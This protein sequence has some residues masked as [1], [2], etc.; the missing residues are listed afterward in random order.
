MCCSGAAAAD[1]NEAHWAVRNDIAAI[2]IQASSS[3]YGPGQ[4]VLLRIG[5]KNMSPQPYAFF[6][7]APW[8]ET[9][10]V[11]KDSSGR[12]IP[13]MHS[14]DTAD[15]KNAQGHAAHVVSPGDTMWLAWNLSEWSDISH[16][17][18]KLAP[19]SYAISAIPMIAGQLPDPTSRY[20]PAG[21]PPAQGKFV[22][23][24]KTPN[25]NTVIIQITR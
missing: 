4:P 18:F 17:G 6:F 23:D 22:T 14:V 13:P 24:L 12:S 7:G 11:V 15:Y 9:T 2:D 20:G 8:I 16:W 1:T 21:L 5:V 19:G 25:S 10:L 3:I